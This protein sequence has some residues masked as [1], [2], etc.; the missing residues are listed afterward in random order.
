[1]TCAGR[2]SWTP[3]GAITPPL[4][5]GALQGFR[6]RMIEHDM[7]P[8]FLE[9]TVE[10]VRSQ[11]LTE[12]EARAVSKALLTA[13]AATRSGLSLHRRGFH[14]PL[15]YSSGLLFNERGDMIRGGELRLLSSQEA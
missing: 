9:R 7:D 5:Q 8:K 3:S 11:C 13:L 14:K 10:H 15:Q 1:L 4:S 12:G 2:W 6:E